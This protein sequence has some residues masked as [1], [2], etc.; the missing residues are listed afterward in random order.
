MNDERVDRYLKEQ[1]ELDNM[2]AQVIERFRSID[3][4]NRYRCAKCWGILQ[5]RLVH[6]NYVEVYCPKCGDNQGTVTQNWI[7]IRKEEDR[8][9][10]A[11]VKANLRRAGVL[12]EPELPPV[13]DYLKVLGYE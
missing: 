13:D 5:D 4:L 7:D 6:Q 12:P 1:D 8:L 3:F 11:E 10:A 9:E 2:D